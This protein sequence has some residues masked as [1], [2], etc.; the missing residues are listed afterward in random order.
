MTNEKAR[1]DG[2]QPAL[3][4]AYVSALRGAVF[5]AAGVVATVV[6]GECGCVPAAVLR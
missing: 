2:G 1:D 4:Y 6:M 3:R 5:L